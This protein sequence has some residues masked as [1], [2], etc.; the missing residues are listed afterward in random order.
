MIDGIENLLRKP[1]EFRSSLTMAAAASFIAMQPVLLNLSPALAAACASACVARGLWRAWAGVRLV[2]YQQRLKRLSEFS[3]SAGDIPWSRSALYLGKGFQWDARHTQR[4]HQLREPEY[5][6]FT[7]PGYFYTKARELERTLEHGR[8][9]SLVELL[10]ADAWWNPV[11]PLPDVGGFAEIHGVGSLDETD[12]WLDLSD[13]TGHTLVEGTTRVG[14]SRLLEI[15]VAQDIRR[16]GAV[17]VFDPKGDEGILRRVYAEAARAGRLSQLNIF[18]LGYPEI[19]ARYNPIGEFARITEIATRIANNMPGGGDSEP[20]RNFVWQFVNNI[21]Q[22][23][24]AL[25]QKLTY[26]GLFAH[27]ENI[28]PLVVDFYKHWLSRTYPGWE[29]EIEELQVDPKSIDKGLR[30]RSIDLIQ[31]VEFAKRKRYHDPIASGLATVVTYE[32]SYFQKLVA[33]LYPFLGKVTTGQI[34]DLL[35]PDY[36]NTDDLRPVFDWDSVIAGGGIVYVGLDAL[37]DHAVA[38]AVGAAMFSDLTA[39]AS[40]IY[41]HG[42]GYGQFAQGEVRPL[43][44]HADE[45]NELIGDE[46]IPMINKAGGAGYRVTAYTQT[47]ADVEARVGDKAK[48]LQIEG[49]FNTRIFMRVLN[50]DTAKL[51]IDSLPEIVIN[52]VT[53]YSSATDTNDPFDSSEFGSGNS[54][55]ISR[56]RV[57]MLCPADLV[58]LPKGQAFIVRKGGRLEK[59]RLPLPIA[60][61]DPVMPENLAHIAQQMGLKY[62]R[63]MIDTP[64]DMSVEEHIAR[65][66]VAGKGAGW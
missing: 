14:K 47:R 62:R 64:A 60:A 34:A 11:R 20:F 31:L 15:L 25:G 3:M 6:H 22:A 1:H 29:R 61:N 21:S 57:P 13:R 9:S 50:E 28:E 66:A 35:S 12:I 7:Q 2:R 30:S 37:E 40:R 4:L 8:F 65:V 55:R 18:H 32:S 44:I 48:S 43:D 26:S 46:F 49:N 5:R 56:E 39:V 63:H 33:S 59:I 58:Q 51:L 24:Y 16:G 42:Q 10:R 53:P 41:K 54:D 45:F 52:S 17:V 23:T 19:S 38:S 36:S 27:A